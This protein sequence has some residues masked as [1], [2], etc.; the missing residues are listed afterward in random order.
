MIIVVANMMGVAGVDHIITLELH[1]SLA[2]GFFNKPCDNLLG[3]PILAKYIA[4]NFP[5][6]QCI[7]VSKNAGGTRRQAVLL[8]HRVTQ[9]AD[10]LRI[11]FALIHRERHHIREGAVETDQIETRITLV[12]D[13][14][15]KICLML[16]D[17]IDQAHS[18]IDSCEHLKK[19]QA[20]K[21]YLV[22]THGILS[23]N[24][25]RQIEVC[26]AIDG[27]IVSNSYPI[28]PEKRATSSKLKQVDI[29]G[30]FAEAI[31]RCHNSESLSYLFYHAI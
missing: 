1:S 23:E 17:V 14:K 30:L 13:V 25:L 31:R 26:S 16:D 7:M 29:S 21:V 18:F 24:A 9:I 3:S 5:L 8:T 4:E 15:D 11:D 22:A 27:I 10:H 6:G 28:P 19:C 12:G 20:A 2:Q